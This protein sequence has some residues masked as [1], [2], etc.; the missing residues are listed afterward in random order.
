M[1]RSPLA[2]KP[3]PI[4]IAGSNTFGRY[5]KISSAETHNMI[6]VDE[7]L[8][9]FAGWQSV[10]TIS[11]SAGGRALY[12][13]TKYK[14]MI[15]V[16]NDGV[17]TIDNN[18]AISRI[19]RLETPSGDV[20]ISENDGNQ[21][22]IVDGLRVYIFNYA[23]HVFTTVVVNF[24]PVHID[25]MDGYFIAADGLTNK[26][27]LSGPN[28]GTSW[29]DD[30]PNVGVLQTKPDISAAVVRFNR[31]VFVFG[32]TVAEPWYDLG[33]Q[34]FPF[35]RDNYVVCDYGCLSAAT[36]AANFDY[37]VWLGGNERSGPTILVSQGSHPKT[38]STDGIN[39]RLAELTNPQDSY[40]FLVK[41]D[42]RICY[43]LTF[44]TDNQTYLLD[45]EA[46]R[47]YTLTDH[48][49]DYFPARSMAFFNNSYYFVSFNDGK[50]YQ[51][52]SRFATADGLTIPRFRTCSSIRL[53]GAKPFVLNNIA[54][55]MAQGNSRE[56]PRVDLSL[57]V[58]GGESWGT[59]QGQSEHPLGKR[60]NQPRFWNLGRANEFIPR[61]AFWGDSQFVVNEAIAE[62]Y[63]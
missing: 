25:F 20:F 1:T 21:I 19:G 47:F 16:V 36:I 10:A 48:N 8:V 11:E 12:K 14:H 62:V 40:G 42:G 24:L 37:L 51:L 56:I 30:A 59:I 6:V 58:D 34:L 43:I 55:T 3:V 57:S 5:P 31:Q 17:Y 26:W 38:I 4:D 33:Y 61:F 2:L 45:F 63:Q 41:I 29:P 35:Q 13:S 60:P 27:R 46:K 15:A 44:R 52:N 7:T 50:L 54:L 32:E 22:G 28:D 49:L 9:S 39:F 18:N 53:K 23:T